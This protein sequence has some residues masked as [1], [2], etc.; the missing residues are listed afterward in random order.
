MTELQVRLKEFEKKKSKSVST[1]TGETN[2]IFIYL[3]NKKTIRS[4][5]SRVHKD[6][7]LSFNFGTSKNFIFTKFMWK[8]FKK[9]LDQIDQILS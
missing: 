5:Y 2:N 4:Y 3:E 6:N 7:V 1:Q 8:K 9:H